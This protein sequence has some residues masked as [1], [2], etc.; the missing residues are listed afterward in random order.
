MIVSKLKY[1]TERDSAN[2]M[3]KEVFLWAVFSI[4]LFNSK[5]KFFVDLDKF[6][7]EFTENFDCPYLV[8]DL[9]IDLLK[10]D[11]LTGRYTNVFINQGVEQIIAEAT[12]I[13]ERS[14]TLIDH[15]ICNRNIFLSSEVIPITITDL[16]AFSVATPYQF[17][18]NQASLQR[19]RISFLHNEADHR[20][21]LFDLE[22]QLSRIDYFDVPNVDMDF[23]YIILVSV[24]RSYATIKTKVSHRKKVPWFDKEVQPAIVKR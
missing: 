13:G 8:R 12:P 19:Q 23:F 17:C 5:A 4:C 15:I 21:M 3:K 16:C 14:S 18:S 6:L 2:S 10:Q 7:E 24:I 22:R 11:S 9:N 1:L 20:K